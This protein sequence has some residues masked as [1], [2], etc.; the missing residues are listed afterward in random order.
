L[1]DP[2]LSRKSLEHRGYRANLAANVH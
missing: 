2:L 1:P